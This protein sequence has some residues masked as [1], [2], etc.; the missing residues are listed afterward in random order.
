[1]RGRADTGVVEGVVNND[2]ITRDAIA[3]LNALTCSVILS[4]HKLYLGYHQSIHST[5]VC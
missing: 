4:S 5:L 1:M 2:G 3:A